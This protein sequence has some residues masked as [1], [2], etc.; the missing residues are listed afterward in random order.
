M[1]VLYLH[2]NCINNYVA[3]SNAHFSKNQQRNRLK[4]ATKH[5]NWDTTSE[6]AKSLVTILL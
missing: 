1:Q 2:H 6:S 3:V 4:W 5:Q